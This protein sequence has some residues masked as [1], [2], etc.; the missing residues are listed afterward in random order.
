[1]LVALA[2]Q[3]HGQGRFQA[4]SEGNAA[5][6]VG[7]V[8]YSGDPSELTVDLS[9]YTGSAFLPQRVPVSSIG[10][11][12][13]GCVKQGPY[14]ITFLSR[15]GHLVHEVVVATRPGENRLT[16][17]IPETHT[18]PARKQ[19]V[20]INELRSK[21]NGK[22]V[23]ALRKAH[24]LR[25]RSQT[26]AA[27]TLVMKV[28]ETD[29]LF[30]DAHI[31][32]GILHADMND[33]EQAAAA[34]R[35]ATELD[36]ARFEA[37]HNLAI[38]LLKLTRYREAEQAARRALQLDR[39]RRSMDCA[40]GISLVNQGRNPEEA[41]KHL[42]RAAPEYPGARLAAAKVLIQTGQKSEAASELKLYLSSTVDAA[43]RA[44]IEAWLARAQ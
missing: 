30:V 8:S 5:C 4:D 19:I 26:V 39:T 17:R 22:A 14:Q 21:V 6:I 33:H 13:L 31:E 34:F 42:L 1:M 41:L 38:E 36:P 15:A 40:L 24:Q 35:K 12:D 25:E 10:S 16:I 18:A 9:S 44:Q 37:H 29:P 2:A 11:F 7:E 27:M 23:S 43:D 32:E 28:L 3:V 20:S